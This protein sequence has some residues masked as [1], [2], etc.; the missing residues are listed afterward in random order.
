MAG[1]FIAIVCAVSDVAS[2]FGAHAIIGI[3]RAAAS[4]IDL[5]DGIVRSL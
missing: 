4:S 2:G 1:A 5:C 3:A